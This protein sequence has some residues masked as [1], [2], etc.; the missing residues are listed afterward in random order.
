M[1]IKTLD[2]DPELDRIGMQPKMVDADPDPE[3]MNPEPKHTTKPVK[4]LPPPPPIS[5]RPTSCEMS[6]NG[7]RGAECIPWVR[8]VSLNICPP[9]HPPHTSPPSTAHLFSLGVRWMPDTPR[10]GIIHSA[11]FPKAPKVLGMRGTPSSAHTP[12]CTRMLVKEIC[13]LNLPIVPIHVVQCTYLLYCTYPL[14]LLCLNNS[15]P[16]YSGIM[17]TMVTM[18]VVSMYSIKSK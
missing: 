14:Y 1:V 5:C 4:G 11:F 10:P 17:G 6:L 15:E 18:Y 7:C 8:K 16:P 9:P 12:Y 2:P 13:A 3:S